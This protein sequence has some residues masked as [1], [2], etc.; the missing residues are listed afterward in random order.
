MTPAED[1]SLYQERVPGVFF[2]LGVNPPGADRV[3]GGSEPLAALLR[4]RERARHRRAGAGQR[5]G[6]LPVSGRS[7]TNRRQRPPSRCTRV[8]ADSESQPALNPYA[9]PFSP[10]VTAARTAAAPA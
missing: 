9:V 6:R 2:F 7:G 10:F 5:G 3:H 1:F 8:K 4:R